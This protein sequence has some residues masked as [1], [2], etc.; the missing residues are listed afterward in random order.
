M[1]TKKMVLVASADGI[2]KGYLVQLD[3]GIRLTP[4]GMAYAEKMWGKFG[5][6]DKLLLA[7]YL[8]KATPDV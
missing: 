6:L 7:G 1:D 8:K 3:K 5:D 2:A 4:A